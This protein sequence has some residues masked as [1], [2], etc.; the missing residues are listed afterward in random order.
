[1]RPI[2]SMQ[3][4]Q[5]LNSIKGFTIIE[6]M[7]ALAISAILIGGI[8]QVFLSLKQTNSVSHALARMQ[9]S[10]RI[11]NDIFVSDARHIGFFGC[12]DPYYA[13]DT[14]HVLSSDVPDHI[15]NLATES[16]DG[17]EVDAIG[18]G[19]GDGLGDIDGSGA[20]NARLNSDVLRAQF[21]SQTQI[22]L[23]IDMSL[24][25]SV[26]QLPNNIFGLKD[27]HIAA[28]GNCNDIDV[29]TVSS[30]T[31]DPV[32]ISHT[33]ATNS[34]NDLSNAYTTNESVRILLSN[35][36]FVGE[37]GRTNINGDTI[38]AL[39]RRDV[40]GAIEEVVEGVENLQILYGEEFAN[41]SIRYVD[42]D[43]A[44]LN[45]N[46]VTSIKIGL[47]IASTER[48]LS[49]ADT[50]TYRVLNE[51]IAQTGTT[52]TYPNDNRL[53]RAVSFSINV[54]NKRVEL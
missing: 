20:R 41:G 44:G 35:T 11:A 10:A 5:N 26:I 38:Y 19:S 28:L 30:Y 18:W 34:S 25:S 36:Y 53:R 7:V 2:M 42:A 31:G 16:L 50:T 33:T 39:Y 52:I 22:P 43:F 32:T 6:I 14:V 49:S 9:E 24:K 15:S 1:M 47:L 37:T 29:F 48:V 3:N 27:G 8:T 46:S 17:W 23:S 4:Q 45:K 40:N 13:S 54:R 12:I 51:N 21:L